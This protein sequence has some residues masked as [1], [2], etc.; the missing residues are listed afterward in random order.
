MNLYTYHCNLQKAAS[1]ENLLPKISKSLGQSFSPILGEAVRWSEKQLADIDLKVSVPIYNENTE[2]FVNKESKHA[3]AF[4]LNS[5]YPNNFV[6]DV[7]EFSEKKETE[8]IIQ[9]IEK[10]IEVSIK[11]S[12]FLEAT[13]LER[14]RKRLGKL[15]PNGKMLA[16]DNL[17]QGIR[18]LYNDSIR[19]KIAEIIDTYGENTLS[20]EAIKGLLK[21]KKSI[22][23]EFCDNSD[24]F[25]K[26]YVIACN[27]CGTPY[28]TFANKEKAKNALAE[29]NNYCANCGK[30]DALNVVEGYGVVETVRRGIQQGLWLE[31]LV[32]DV[33]SEF[34]QQ[35]W[36]GQMVDTDELDG[37]S[38]YCDK[39]ILIECKDTSFGQN[40]FYVTAMKAQDIG[41]DIVVIITTHEIH[42][43][44]QNNIDRYNK[45]SERTFKIITKTS[46]KE[47]K[48]SLEDFL[49]E[50]QNKYVAKW[51]RG[52]SEGYFLPHRFSKRIIRRYR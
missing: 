27:E 39:I 12:S 3:F 46:T 38:I 2:V 31:S 30:K 50:T 28:L 44:V 48:S 4:R 15:S 35:I 24:L 40:D 22:I 33:V 13:L 29:S 43:N 18:R 21:E 32:S 26:K 47:I 45:E 11:E 16:D 19:S 7:L 14:V 1:F 41:A 23:K 34:T 6:L 36:A 5:F 51:F 49:K 42:P 10:A 20:L 25:V 9:L 37:L 52:G 17:R 8:N